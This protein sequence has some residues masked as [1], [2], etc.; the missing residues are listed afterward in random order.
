MTVPS[1]MFGRAVV[2]TSNTLIGA[3]QRRE[4][5]V[6]RYLLDIGGFSTVDALRGEIGASLVRSRVMETTL[7]YVRSVMNGNFDIIK[8]M[9]QHTIE[10]KTGKWYKA[11]NSYIEELGIEWADVGQMTKEEIKRLIRNH[12]NKS[13]E[14]NLT[15][16]STLKFYK[17]GKTRIGYESCYRNNINS[18]FLAR[19]RINS[20]KLEEAIG[21]GKP[22]YDKSCKLCYQ[23]EEDLVHF[24]VKCPV[25][26]RMRDYD[27][28]DKRIQ[29]PKDR[30]IELLFRQNRYQEVGNMLKN[31]WNRRK[32]ILKFNEDE[33]NRIEAMND[34]V[35][36]TRSDP[37][38][39]ENSYTPIERGMRALSVSRG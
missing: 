18:M 31:L 14:D 16:K 8:K 27:L 38:P 20:L 35:S 7:Q 1:I 11:V 26:E 23:E 22:H 30:M 29:D 12:D 36:S 5:K 34:T 33:R 4:N 6:W 39:E 9:M 19:A 24:T 13:W 28:I 21:R 17:E 25:L 37:G 10:V 3:L 32:C 15:N 2:P